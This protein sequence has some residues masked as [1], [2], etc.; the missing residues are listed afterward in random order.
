MKWSWKLAKIAGIGVYMHATFLLLIG[1][2]VLTFWTQGG[3]IAET[4]EAVLF[5]LSL[6]AL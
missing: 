5:V 6:F 2:I 4:L 3:G 1:W